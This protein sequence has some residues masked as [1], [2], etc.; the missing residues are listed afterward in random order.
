MSTTWERP[1]FTEIKMDAEFTSYCEDLETER[2]EGPVTLG[3]GCESE[4]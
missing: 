1:T 3:P 2:V 4:S